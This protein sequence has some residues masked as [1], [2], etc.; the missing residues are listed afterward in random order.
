MRLHAVEFSL[1]V[2]FP[3]QTRP[4]Q[5][6]ASVGKPRELRTGTA[7]NVFGT[8]CGCALLITGF[9]GCCGAI[10]CGRK[11]LDRVSNDVLAICAAG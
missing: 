1:S 4:V 2:E 5:V 3:K 7:A 9:R 8:G 11:K 10:G 6:G